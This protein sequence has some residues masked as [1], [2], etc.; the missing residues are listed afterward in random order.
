MDISYISDVKQRFD[1][2]INRRPSSHKTNPHRPP[3][4]MSLSSSFHLLSFQRKVQDALQCVERTLELERKPRLAAD[5][6]H[7]YGAKYGL[8]NLTSN[9]AIIAYMNCLE[10]LGLDTNALKSIDKTK[11]TTL[12]FDASTTWKFLKEVVMDL[13]AERS[14]EEKEET[15]GGILSKKTRVMKV[16]GMNT[17]FVPYP[18]PSFLLTHA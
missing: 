9:A 14:W 15:K 3:T 2:L 12:R 5:V 6:D 10:R 18:L 13:P 16:S 11:P 17:C 7:T 1:S 4:T 8:V